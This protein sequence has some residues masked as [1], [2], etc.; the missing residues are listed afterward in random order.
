[1][2]KRLPALVVGAGVAGLLWI[3]GPSAQAC[4]SGPTRT[5]GDTLAASP[6]GTEVYGAQ[7]G[8]TAGQIGVTGS[9]G[10]IEAGGDEVNGAYV[11][12]H[13]SGDEL[14]GRVGVSSAGPD[15]CVN[16]QP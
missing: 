13:S 3:G 2:K 15:V 16:D 14:Y 11:Q 10:Y 5:A 4:D 8:D 7:T 1:M 9:N 6:T 12:G